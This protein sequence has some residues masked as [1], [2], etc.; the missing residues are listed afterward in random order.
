MAVVRNRSGISSGEIDYHVPVERFEKQSV[1]CLMEI[2]RELLFL[3]QMVDDRM[4]VFAEQ[5]KKL[6]EGTDELA[7]RKVEP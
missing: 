1:G 5:P 2:R 3:I 6:E 7:P 4:R